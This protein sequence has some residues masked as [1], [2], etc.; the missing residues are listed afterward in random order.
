MVVPD[1]RTAR[2]KI[3][4]TTC[5]VIKREL[6]Y[7]DSDDALRGQRRVDGVETPR[8]RA[9]TG[10]NIA[11]MAWGAKLDCTQITTELGARVKIAFP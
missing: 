8:H 9:D 10:D 6:G 11:T 2:E 7:C 5:V 1:D 4:I 3:S